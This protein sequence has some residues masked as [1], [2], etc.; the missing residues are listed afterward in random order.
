MGAGRCAIFFPQEVAELHSK[1]CHVLLSSKAIAPALKCFSH[2]MATQPALPR[3]RQWLEGFVGTNLFNRVPGTNKEEESYHLTLMARADLLAQCINVKQCMEYTSDAHHS[4]HP[5]EVS[6]FSLVSYFVDTGL[7]HLAECNQRMD[8]HGAF[9]GD[10]FC[11]RAVCCALEVGLCCWCCA[12]ETQFR[13]PASR[14]F[15]RTDTDR[16]V[17][18]LCLQTN[19]LSISAQTCVSHGRGH[20]F[21]L[22]VLGA[23]GLRSPRGFFD[24]YPYWLCSLRGSSS[25]W[26]PR[27][28]RGM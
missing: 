25:R 3:L 27:T 14:V 16:A 20:V 28:A 6:M 22:Y 23:E 7:R 13:A 1:L 9:S 5:G 24:P 18:G 15:R 21:G 17:S 26:D 12:P 11:R 2:L 19:A 4:V 8:G 10:T